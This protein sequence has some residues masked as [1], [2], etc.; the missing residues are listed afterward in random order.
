MEKASS[1]KTRSKSIGPGGLD[2]LKQ[3]LGNRRMV[4][5]S[6]QF[7][8]S[9][10]KIPQ[11]AVARIPKSILMPAIPLSPLREIP[12]RKPSPRRNYASPTRSSEQKSLSPNKSIEIASPSRSPTRVLLAQEH[13]QETEEEIQARRA[14]RERV[15]KHREA[16]RKSMAARRVSFAPEATLHTWDVID[17]AQDST[18]SSA[19][20]SSTRQSTASRASMA[21]N[22]TD[23]PPS[24]PPKQ[25]DDDIEVAHSPE[26]QRDVHQ[27]K[28]RRRSS[29]IPPMNFNDPDAL[30]SSDYA[31]D[32]EEEGEI[33]VSPNKDRSQTSSSPS[34]SISDDDGDASMDLTG[35]TFMDGSPSKNGNGEDTGRLDAALEQ[36]ANHAGRKP[37]EYDEDGDVSM[38]IAG[39]EVTAAFKPWVQT[40]MGAASPHLNPKNRLS[41]ASD[42]ENLVLD[43]ASPTTSSAGTE[44][45][46]MD[47]TKAIGGI[48]QQ[49]NIRKP[50]N[51]RR[52][53]VRSRRASVAAGS[54]AGDGTMAMDFTTAI[55]GIQPKTDIE[56]LTQVDEN[57]ELSM[58]F[59][60]VFGGLKTVQPQ[61]QTYSQQRMPEVR[62]DDEEEGGEMEMTT[63]VGGI[64]ERTRKSIA[65]G[66]G[67]LSFT[68]SATGSPAAGGNRIVNQMSAKDALLTNGTPEKVP[69]T[70][71]KQL[72][73]QPKQ[74][75]HPGKTPPSA[76]VTMRSASPRKLFQAEIKAA[77]S[78]LASA[79]KLFTNGQDGSRT[80]NV[81]L[82]P[83][84]I[85][86]L[87][88][89]LSTMDPALTNSPRLSAI[90][91]RRASI[92]DQAESFSPKPVGSAAV[93]FADP[94][95]LE[96]EIDREREE[97]M[98]R[99]SGQYIMEKEANN[100]PEEENA[101]MT[102]REM[103]HSMT[104]KKGSS[105]VKGSKSLHVGAAR[106]VLGK[107]PAEL[108]ESDEERSPFKGREA[109]P[110][111]KIR[112][113][114]PQPLSAKK[115]I[116]HLPGTNR[117][118]TPTGSPTRPQTI[119]TPKSQGRFKDAESVSSA[120]KPITT[121]GEQADPNDAVVFEDHERANIKLQDFLNMTGIR[122]MDTLDTTKRRHTIAPPKRGEKGTDDFFSK[123]AAE[124]FEEAA[125]AG[126]TTVP[127][128]DLFQHACH[129]TKQYIRGGRKILRQLEDQSSEE[130][131]E[132]FRQ[133][134]TAA[135]EERAKMDAQF[136]NIKT[137]AR[138]L[139][140]ASWYE[141]RSKLWD[142]LKD[143]LEA[144]LAGLR[145]DHAIV[146]DTEDFVGQALPALIE[147]KELLAAEHT[148]LTAR[149]NDL[150]GSDPKALN[151]ARERL[152]SMD[153][154]ME[155][156]RQQIKQF[157]ED[158]EK[159]NSSIEAAIEAKSEYQAAI[160]EAHR[161]R[162]ECRGWSMSEVRKLRSEVS[163]L[164]ATT[165]WSITSASASTL[166]MVYRSQLQL[167]FD[168]SAF[169][170]T[171]GT[172]AAKGRSRQS[173]TANA[174]ISLTYAVDESTQT[175]S[176]E[177]RFFL[178]IMR[179]H[180]QSLQQSETNIKD[181]LNLVS[182]GWTN[183]MSIVNEV[184]RL[185]MLAPSRCDIISDEHMLCQRE[186]RLWRSL[187][188][189]E[190][191]GISGG[192]CP[193]R[194]RS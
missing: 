179:A 181:L 193:Q 148:H 82:A 64:L 145:D 63:A 80:P 67:R 133:Y 70:P 88:R 136:K 72:T 186:V 13:L 137:H 62:E 178:Q 10:T 17:N 108:D 191:Q 138:F 162:E 43:P 192:L 15:Q 65:S 142:G 129:E 77:R 183:A 61:M 27:T 73:P 119:S 54:D 75:H 24:T 110:V 122:F 48:M 33:A 29:T 36:A 85:T 81:V 66:R 109:S 6:D 49:G 182:N 120:R 176:T 14:E 149:G 98:R 93:R 132:I 12:S 127:L 76:K 41:S 92:N 163:A 167:Y 28:R 20:T 5:L 51:N 164:E 166:T 152:R 118:M 100:D 44:D 32:S 184:A 2:S 165:G 156:K 115:T 125:V 102:L 8:Y 26:H 69:S 111:K 175:L 134:L 172:S 128:Y 74:P 79:S 96:A 170:P 117:P 53:S 4:R 97:E 123:D 95:R 57:E 71:S 89:R 90:L 37:L 84:S 155:N 153:A 16:R 131:P 140:K 190:D 59:T 40:A 161:R 189:D 106:G 31:S 107:R 22:V 168:T 56:N 46:S 187:Q 130:N 19:S 143:S 30:S 78:P 9:A 180:L 157:Q 86:D 99:E 3:D 141:W 185:N 39:D 1:K 35:A 23:D 58:E 7:S 151:S 160:K 114:G 121:F 146:K 11:S 104:P 171:T 60:S 52:Q 105:K 116:S 113:Q 83:K 154:D 147:E 18:T 101:T 25:A 42:Q 38:E 174:P 103:M 135:P 126:A 87:Q 47:M 139:S 169:L 159:R 173:T 194:R 91:S 124:I 45:M 150:K 158:L 55:G 112:L 177:K 144:N 21:S 188:G 34:A 50:P 68:A 94:R